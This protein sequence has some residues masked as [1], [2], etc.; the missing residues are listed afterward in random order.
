MFEHQRSTKPV[1]NS[2]KTVS[3]MTVSR[4]NRIN[5]RPVSWEVAK[6]WVLTDR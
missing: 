1:D 3:I 2:G 6:P 5:G 4:R